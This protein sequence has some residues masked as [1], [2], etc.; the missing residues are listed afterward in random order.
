[1]EI[2]TG[3]P[4]PAVPQ[5]GQTELNEKAIAA[6]IAEQ[7]LT[8]IPAQKWEARPDFNFHALEWLGISETDFKKMVSNI[9]LLINRPIILDRFDSDHTARRKWRDEDQVPSKYGEAARIFFR[10]N[11][12]RG[13]SS[14][15]PIMT[16]VNTLELRLRKSDN[17]K[18]AEVIPVLQ[19]F[20]ED[21]RAAKGE[22][23]ELSTDEKIIAV[24]KIDL[25]L[26]NLLEDLQ[27]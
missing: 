25:L 5:A 14:G 1:M 15:T 19:K 11:R 24:K 20:R 17:A 27:K 21:Y 23:D 16:F 22:Y 7:G 3:N 9:S 13:H 10:E 4:N 8:V 26:Q 12:L 18:R 2:K 6:F